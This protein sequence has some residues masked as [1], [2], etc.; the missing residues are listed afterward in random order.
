MKLYLADANTAG[1]KFAPAHE[2]VMKLYL[3]DANTNF[4]IKLALQD[5]HMKIYLADGTT[6]MNKHGEHHRACS[7]G[8]TPRPLRIL[9]SYHYFKNVDLDTAFAKAFAKPYPE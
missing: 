6:S 7:L 1:A 4:D 8:L 2:A 3:A 9:L 5:D